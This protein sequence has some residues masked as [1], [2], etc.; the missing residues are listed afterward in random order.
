MLRENPITENSFL[1]M[2]FTAGIKNHEAHKRERKMASSRN[3]EEEIG[4]LG[5]NF[6]FR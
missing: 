4:E 2:P 6:K 1:I 3:S 5:L